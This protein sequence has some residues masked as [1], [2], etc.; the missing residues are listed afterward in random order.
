MHDCVT[1]PFFFFFLELC[2]TNIYLDMLQ[3]Y[4]I[5]YL[6]GMEQEEGEILFEQHCAPPHFSHDVPNTLNIT[7]SNRRTGKVG[8][9][10]WSPPSPDLLPPNTVYGDV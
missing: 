10:P 1:G 7:F 2:H 8:S 6:V 9:L 3:L 4:I 5:P